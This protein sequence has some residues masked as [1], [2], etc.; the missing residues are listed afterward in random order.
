MPYCIAVGRPLIFPFKH[1]L[2]EAGFVGQ[3]GA[4][5]RSSQRALKFSVEWAPRVADKPANLRGT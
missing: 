2:L 1:L 5:R 3:V 4:L